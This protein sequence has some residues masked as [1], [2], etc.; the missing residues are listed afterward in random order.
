MS[1]NTSAQP[2]QHGSERRRSIWIAAN[3]SWYVYNFRGNLISRLIEAGYEVTAYAPADNYVSKLEA[4]GARHISMQLDSSSVNPLHELVALVL[5]WRTLRTNRPDL[6]LTFTPKVNIYVSLA[7]MVSQ[8]PVVANVSGLGRSFGSSAWIARVAAG[9]YRIALRVPRIVFFQNEEDRSQFVRSG[10]VEVAKT[11][12]LPGSGVD[13]QRFVPRAIPRTS[14]DF[15]FLLA[16]RLIWDK[17]VGI[18]AEAARIVRGGHPEAKFRLLGSIDP[19]N[20]ASVPDAQIAQWTA[21]SLIDYLGMTDD[22]PAHY[23]QSDCVV[24]PSYYREG[25]P[26]VL[27][28]AAAMA[29]PVITT[30]MPGCRDVVEH[31]V[32]GFLCAPRD[33]RDLADKMLALLRLPAD[34]RAEMGR[35]G[36]L[37]MEREF[38]E[39]LVIAAYMEAVAATDK[40]NIGRH[41]T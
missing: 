32:T 13:L 28:E 24:L 20:P 21:E 18:F 15:V 17:G 19:A 41:E 4:L 1:E 10:W 11:R 25:V 30:D 8:F 34:A 22:V 39:C 31:G 6:V 16:A 29:L 36:R 14:E 35:S 27:L 12:R 26:R 23:A 3:T 9:L 40:P 2:P 37:K 5:L 38:D 7:A 33:A